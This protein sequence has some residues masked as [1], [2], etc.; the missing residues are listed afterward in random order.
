MSHRMLQVDQNIQRELSP[1][2][3]EYFDWGNALVTVTSVI[4][5]P[6]LRTATAWIS[7]LNAPNPSAVIDLL[8]KRSYDIYEPLASRLTMKHVPKI[9]FKLDDK[10]DDLV[11]LDELI[12]EASGHN[13]MGG[14][15]EA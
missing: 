11:R 8:N 9:E 13:P 15:R 10:S 1:L 4:T 3:L 7:V 5:T 14:S 12:D 2:L 6:D